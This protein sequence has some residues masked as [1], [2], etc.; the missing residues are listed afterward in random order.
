MKLHSIH[1][2][3]N[4]KLTV[5][6]HR[7]KIFDASSSET[8][9]PVLENIAHCLKVRLNTFLIKKKVLAISKFSGIL[10]FHN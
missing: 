9:V 4:N 2:T 5:I 7:I 10:K 6:R 8:F 1:Q 3:F